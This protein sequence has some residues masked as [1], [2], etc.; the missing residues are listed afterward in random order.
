MF[1]VKQVWRSHNRYRNTSRGWKDLNQGIFLS[2]RYECLLIIV[3][4]H[5]ISVGTYYNMKIA[6]SALSCYHWYFFFYRIIMIIHSPTFATAEP[7]VTFFNPYVPVTASSK[8]YPRWKQWHP[9]ISPLVDRLLIQSSD[10]TK[11]S[12]PYVRIFP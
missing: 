2:C 6:Q 5:L 12:R 1:F 7:L 8:F 3:Y 9:P 4:S 10:V 11:S